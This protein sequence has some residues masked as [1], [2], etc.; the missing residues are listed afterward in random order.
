MFHVSPAQGASVSKTIPLR[1]IGAAFTL[2]I[3]LCLTLPASATQTD[4]TGPAGSG[5]FGQSVTVLPNGN[6]VVTDPTYDSSNP[7]VADVGAVYLYNGTT[8]ALISTL[9]GSTAD[10]SVGNFGITVLTNGNFVV[11]SP[12]WDNGALDSA[13]AAT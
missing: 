1:A 11:R 10:D 3:I 4:I 13:G 2:F 6:I 5:L 8:L 12:F 7:T 9:V